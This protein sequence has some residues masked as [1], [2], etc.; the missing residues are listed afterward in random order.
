MPYRGADPLP[1][2]PAETLPSG[3]G[4]RGKP[5]NGEPD[6]GLLVMV[7]TAKLQGELVF[8]QFKATQYSKALLQG[9]RH[10]QRD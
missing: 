8:L 5:P 9:K 1:S 6:T 10:T 2:S 3:D 7:P 4:K